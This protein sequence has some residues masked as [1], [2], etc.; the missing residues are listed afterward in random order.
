MRSNATEMF[1]NPFHFYSVLL[2]WLSVSVNFSGCRYFLAAYRCLPICG[3]DRVKV[4]L[5][6]LQVST[7]SLSIRSNITLSGSGVYA[8]GFPPKIPTI[9][10]ATWCKAMFQLSG[11]GV[12][13][14]LA[15]SIQSPYLTNRWGSKS[16]AY[17]H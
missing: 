15:D 14:G 2:S 7:S 12:Q 9:S 5:L 13:N 10:C 3:T 1:K 11:L 6:S 8:G 16:R 17:E 4:W